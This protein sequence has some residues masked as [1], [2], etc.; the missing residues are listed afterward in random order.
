MLLFSPFLVCALKF[1]TSATDLSFLLLPDSALISAADG[2]AK[3]FSQL[4]RCGEIIPETGWFLSG[5][6]PTV[7][8]HRLAGP[9]NLAMALSGLAA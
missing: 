8:I 5:F 4:L 9:L 7:E 6:E 3:I 1:A 2:A